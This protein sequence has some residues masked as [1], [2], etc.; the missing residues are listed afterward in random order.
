MALARRYP[1]DSGPPHAK[2]SAM[3][4]LCFER[5]GATT[6]VVIIVGEC[7]LAA[8]MRVAIAGL[9]KPEEFAQGHRLEERCATALSARDIGRELSAIEAQAV[10][11]R[12]E[13]SLRKPPAPSVRRRA[14]GASV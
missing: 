4:W 2:F 13:G 8:R 5:N 1:V 11:P 14:R 6:C 12:I 3:W 7:L 10:L 9:G